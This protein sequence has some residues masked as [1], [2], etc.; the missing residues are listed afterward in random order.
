MGAKREKAPAPDAPP[1]LLAALDATPGARAGFDALPPGARRE[2][3]EWVLGAKQ[4]ATRARRI[5]TTAAQT[6][7]GKKLHWKYEAC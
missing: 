3:V 4:P 7:E 6:A 2:Y 1:D 5:E